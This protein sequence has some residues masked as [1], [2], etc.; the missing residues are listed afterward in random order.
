MI[1][2]YRGYKY[3]YSRDGMHIFLRLTWWKCYRVE[4]TT[5]QITSGEYRKV[6]DKLLK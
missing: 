1:P 4:L 5:S 6:I 3:G 2:E